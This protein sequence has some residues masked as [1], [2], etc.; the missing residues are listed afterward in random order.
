MGSDDDDR[1]PHLR[2]NLADAADRFQSADTRHLDVHQHHFGRVFLE[3]RHGG[4]AALDAG[5]LMA[6]AAKL[7]TDQ[8]ADGL[9]VIGEENT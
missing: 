4:L 9:A 7:V 5:D 8:V 3:G 6:V 2:R 1:Y